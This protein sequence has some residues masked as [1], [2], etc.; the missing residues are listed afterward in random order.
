MTASVV[1]AATLGP[2]SFAALVWGA[3]ALVALG[4]GYV[5]WTLVADSRRDR[6]SK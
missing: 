5:V 2:T 4:F 1:V 3:I 6:A